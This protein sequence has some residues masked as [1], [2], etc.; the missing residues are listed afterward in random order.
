MNALVD[1][2]PIAKARR[3]RNEGECCVDDCHNAAVHYDSDNSGYCLTHWQGSDS[4]EPGQDCAELMFSGDQGYWI[5][6]TQILDDE[7]LGFT[8]KRKKSKGIGF[9]YTYRRSNH[10]PVQTLKRLLLPIRPGMPRVKLWK[11][12]EVF[13]KADYS[14]GNSAALDVDYQAWAED[15]EEAEQ[16]IAMSLESGS[17]D[18]STDE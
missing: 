5:T 7:Q 13:I 12:E 16:L 17:A 15:K 1:K 3:G 18:D 2:S 4:L 6:G 9:V 10:K 8:F 11:W 14:Q